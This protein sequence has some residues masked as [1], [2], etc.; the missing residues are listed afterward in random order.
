MNNINDDLERKLNKARDILIE[1]KDDNYS[2]G[3]DCVS[4]VGEYTALLGKSV[5]IIASRSKWLSGFVNEVMDSLRKSKV[6]IIDWVD[7]AKPNTPIEDVNRIRDEICK[8]NPDCL[9]VIAGGSGIDAA[10]AAAILAAYGDE[11][12]DISRFYGVGEVTRFAANTGIRI[13]SIVAVQTAA[14]SA[15]H[16]TKYANVTDL[17]SNQKNLIVDEEIM[18][19][20][21]I[22]DYTIT[23]SMSM[24]L[25]LDGAL[26]GMSHALEV[27]YGATGSTIDYVEKVALLAIE[28]IVYALPRIIND[29]EN[30]KLREILGLATDLGGYC[31][32][33]GA[34]NGGH[35][36]SFSLVDILSHGRA[37][38]IANIYYTVF[39]AP[40][41]QRQLQNLAEIFKSYIPEDVDEISGRRLG[42]IVAQGMIAFM[43]SL[44]L[45]TQLS[46]VNGFSDDHIK[47]ALTAAKDPKLE[48]KLKS[49]PLSLNA[50][51]VDEY[52]APLLE[53]AKS[54]DISLIKDFEE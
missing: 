10:K 41:I 6:E 44:Y 3:F 33:L 23:R 37:C 43:K 49:M 2:F 21:A 38:G 18:P 25:T 46:E 35:L 36:T 30:L 1:F 9:V 16:L 45:P 5:L 22:F 51:L 39:F 40:R 27:Y 7:G 29:P 14:S 17:R 31:I 19:P 15:S 12:Y 48:S 20:K 42:E 13:R 8:S 34:T 47:R 53:A 54:G 32:M 26:D 4:R 28:L 24:D 52:I 11:K 50:S